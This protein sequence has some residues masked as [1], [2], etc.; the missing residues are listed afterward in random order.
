MAMPPLP[1]QGQRLII[2][3]RAATRNGASALAALIST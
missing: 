3:A 1:E 2:A